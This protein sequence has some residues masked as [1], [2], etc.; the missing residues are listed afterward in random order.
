[1]ILSG[2]VWKVPERR[3]GLGLDQ[4]VCVEG[5]KEYKD[6]PT[7]VDLCSYIGCKGV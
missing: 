3:P 4:G 7:G 1:M 2:V 5:V 6:L